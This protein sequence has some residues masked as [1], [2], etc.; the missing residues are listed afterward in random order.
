MSPAITL[1]EV[2]ALAVEMDAAWASALAQGSTESPN[3]TPLRVCL[4]L[5][6]CSLAVEHGRALRELL[7][8]G[9]ESSAI[10]L[11]R[12]Q[13]ESLLRAAWICFA[14]PEKAIEEL[15]A[16]LTSTTLK[17]ANGLPMA[18]DLLR[19]VELSDAPA[20]LKR[21]LREFRDTSWAAVNSY[22]HAGLMALGRAVFGHV[23]TQL[24]QAVQVAN[25][26][27]YAAYM[28]AAAVTNPD[29]QQAINQV[30]LLHPE[31]VCSRGAL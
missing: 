16:P 14:A 31:C 3:E 30:A 12:V 25:A 28:L 4:T 27:A 13:H 29:T 23:E 26:H 20:E 9:L 24:V 7:A 1:P 10:G 2:L 5:D 18:S 22:S 6:A 11:L 15:G 19:A 8:R 17:R 21:G